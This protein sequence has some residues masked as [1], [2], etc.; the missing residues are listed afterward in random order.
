MTPEQRSEAARK[1][2]SPE[3]DQKRRESM[4]RKWQDPEYQARR[5]ET[6]AN[7]EVK[8]RR[9][10]A[11]KEMNNRASRRVL[12]S[13]IMRSKFANDP[14]FRERH[15]AAMRAAAASPEYHDVRSDSMRLAWAEMRG[16]LANSVTALQEESRTAS[17]RARRKLINAY[18]AAENP[19]SPQEFGVALVL[20]QLDIQYFIHKVISTGRE[21]DIAVPSFMINFEVDGS[22]HGPNAEDHDKKRD[23][24]VAAAGYSIVR[25][26]HRDFK[27]TAYITKICNALFN[28]TRSA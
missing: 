15:A 20:N 4:Q 12:Q 26:P 1:S 8:A 27:T 23:E 11:A 24:E 18:R 9:V 6:E 14:E 16:N 19:A 28:A 5:A 25:I 13:E 22:N 3:S 7:P 21:L 10:A 2:H 17:G